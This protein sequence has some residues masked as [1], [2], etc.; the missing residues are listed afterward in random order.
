MK[1]VD[2][3][4]H[5]LLDPGF[6]VE[7]TSSAQDTIVVEVVTDEDIVGVGETDL[8]AWIA[9]ACI[10]APGTHTMD[11]GLRQMLIGRDPLEPE[12]IWE[13]L[14]V[15]SA[16]SGRRGAVVHALGAL[17]IALWDICGKAAGVPCWRLWGEAARSELTPYASLQPEVESFEAYVDSMVTW[18]TRAR[19]MGFQACKLEAT[20][21]GPYVHKRL[22]GPDERIA[23]V[24]GAVRAA[25]GREM[26]IMVDVQYAFDSVERALAAITMWDGLDVFFLETPLWTDDVDG[27]AELSSASPVPIAAGEWLSTRHDFAVLIDRGGVQVVQPD[28]G[29][30]G[31]FTEARRVCALAAER[32]RM[33]VPHAWKTGLS[34]AA[35]AQLAMVTPHMPFFEFLPVELCE[36]RLRKELTIDELVFEDGVLRPPERPGIGVDLNYDALEE[37]TV[38]AAEGIRG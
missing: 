2:V 17:D 26:T 35:A 12:R 19:A 36:S 6:D 25:V 10:E 5:V 37:F 38:A 15:G 8:N 16:M 24:I 34:V 27:Y 3:R 1:V 30:V 21:S 32:G 23:E 13:D 31:G 4:T 11:R 29:R 18:A 22:I 7:A 33:I 28:I 20:F 14:Y 9:R